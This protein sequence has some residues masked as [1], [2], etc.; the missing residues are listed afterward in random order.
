MYDYKQHPKFQE[1]MNAAALGFESAVTPEEQ[2]QVYNQWEANKQSFKFYSQDYNNRFKGQGDAYKGEFDY[3]SVMFNLPLMDSLKRTYGEQLTDEE[4]VGAW[5]KEQRWLNTN[6][7]KLGANAATLNNLDAQQKED[8][9][10]QYQTYEQMGDV[11][12]GVLQK[13]ADFAPAVLADP[14]NYASVATLG[15][16]AGAKV[17]GQVAAKEAIK[18]FIIKPSIKRGALIGAADGM[19]YATA[20]DAFKQSI[21]RDLAIQDDWDWGDTANSAIL[22]TALGGTL[23]GVLTFAADRLVPKIQNLKSQ[24][25]TNEGV[26]KLLEEA[27]G[28]EATATKFLQDI[29]FKADEAEAMIANVKVHQKEIGEYQA[30]EANR[31]NSFQEFYDKF[32][33]SGRTIMERMGYKKLADEMD[34]AIV[35]KERRMGELDIQLNKTRDEIDLED[36]GLAKRYRDNKPLTEA[37]GQMF[38]DIRSFQQKNLKDA[39]K[40][41]IVDDKTFGKLKANTSY[42]PRVW[43]TKILTTKEGSTM[44]A[45]DLRELTKDLPESEAKVRAE[46]IINSLTG[47]KYTGAVDDP[48]LAFFIR[49][50]AKVREQEVTRSTHLEHTRKIRGIPEATLDKYMLPFEARVKLA[51]NDI[52][53]RIAFAERF[54]KN[55]D[56]VVNLVNDLKAARKGEEADAVSEYYGITAGIPF[57]DNRQFGS[58]VLRVRRD[59]PKMVDFVNKV[60]GVQTWKMYMSAIPNLPQAIINGITTVTGNTN[61]AKGLALGFK[62]PIKAIMKDPKYM[63]ALA[64]SGVLSELDMHKFLS[65]GLVNTRVIDKDFKG[66]LGILNEPT[67]FLRAVGFFGVETMNR[68]FASVMG[69]MEAEAMHNS[70]KGLSG[71]AKLS[72]RDISKLNRYEKELRRLRIDPK[73]DTLDSEDLARAG[74]YF[75]NTVNFSNKHHDMPSTW[76]HPYGKVIFKFKSFMF[77][78]GKF[79]KDKVLK[80]IKERGDIGPMIAYVGIASPVGAA[81]LQLRE[82]MT[83]KEFQKEAETF[84]YYLRGVGFAGGAGLWLDFLSMMSKERQSTPY[85]AGQF[86]GPAMGDV[87]RVVG[88]PLSDKEA[89]EKVVKILETAFPFIKPATGHIKY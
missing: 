10:I 79:V 17:V 62:A 16:F 66:P 82:T 34:D 20:H 18:N 19:V 63:E 83:G 9:S 27:S 57:D 37:E 46:Q 6:L 61:L 81:L 48:E 70:Y 8:F 14:S 45:N 2:Q 25:L 89:E 13:I 86:V 58:K 85:V 21:E 26:V 65:E 47:E 23:G 28:D 69:M 71:K 64:K 60:N 5:V 49:R 54:G 59:N 33:T 38:N 55:D 32:G 30:S 40:A 29:G 15:L 24:G 31:R 12:D 68:K 73:K 4:L 56:K 74:N 7:V 22:G 76:Q 78:H 75:N 35:A 88:T 67:R 36:A 80:P 51:N 41:G 3:N 77:H 39:H 72:K 84:D 44:L 53:Q 52:A 50:A 43:N 42:L 87:A 11:D 1:Q